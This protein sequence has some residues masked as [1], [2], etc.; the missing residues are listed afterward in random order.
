MT[1]LG[2]R[3]LID[4]T[5][6]PGTFRSWDEPIDRTGYDAGYRAALERAEA[7]TGTDE[8]VLTGR[9]L[10]RG[11]ATALVVSEFGFLGGSIGVAT[12]ERVATAVRRATRER[13][14]LIAATASGQG[15]MGFSLELIRT[16]SLGM[17]ARAERPW[18]CTAS[19]EAT[20]PA[21]AAS[22]AARR[23]KSRLLKPRRRKSRP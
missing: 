16:A 5:V 13:L 17:S 1:R 20:P 10:I 6:D 12:A 21:P 19:K 8:A 15:P 3:A 7:R 2:A 11:H 4:A 14:P 9:A 18:A 23:P 22:N